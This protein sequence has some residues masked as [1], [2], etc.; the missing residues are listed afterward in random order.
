VNKADCYHLGHIA[1]LHG[2]K[3]EVSLFLDVTNPL[4]YENLDKIF[5][6]IN[7]FLTPFF[8]KSISLKPKNQAVIRI[9][10]INSDKEAT[11]VVKRQVYLPLNDLP[12][13]SGKNFYDHEVVGFEL[14][15]LNFGKVGFIEQIIDLPVN[16]LIQVQ[17][18]DGKEV[19]IPFVKDLI[20]EVKRNEKQLIVKAPEGLIAIYLG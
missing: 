13:L 2:F 8:I 1:K 7:G 16:P 9:D 5:V 14:I 17:S 4:E 15:D 19:L 11:Q 12:Q 10:G 3:G 18:N 6:D 20:Q